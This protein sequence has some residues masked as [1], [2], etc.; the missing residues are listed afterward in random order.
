MLEDIRLGPFRLD[1]DL[2][3][4][5]TRPVSYMTRGSGGYALSNIGTWFGKMH[6]RLA[7]TRSY[8][9]VLQDIDEVL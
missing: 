4:T 5:R 6:V 7:D 8:G 3:G 2:E 1:P 9:C